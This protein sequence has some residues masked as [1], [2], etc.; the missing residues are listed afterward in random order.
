VH[1]KVCVLISSAAN[2]AS[3]LVAWWVCS[4][5]LFSSF[6]GAHGHVNYI[7]DLFWQLLCGSNCWWGL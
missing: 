4:E 5:E 2:M 7:T 6:C 1:Y 3:V